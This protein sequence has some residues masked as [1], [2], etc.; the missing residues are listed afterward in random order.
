MEHNGVR[1]LSLSDSA[2]CIELGQGIDRETNAR[3]HALCRAINAASI[4]GVTET[5]PTYRSLAVHYDMLKTGQDELIS[6][7]LPIIDGIG[8]GEHAE[9]ELVRIPVLYGGEWGADIETVARL[10]SLSVDEVI[11]IH[12]APEYPV[13]MLGFLP[14][15][16]YLGGMDARIAAP[17]LKTPRVRIEPGS[18][19][20]A[21]EQ[22]GIYPIASPGGW[23]LIGRTPLS[24]YSPARE[25]PILLEAGLRIKF[26]SINRA[27]YERIRAE[28]EAE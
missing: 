9:G 27:E 19:G 15:F 13:Y 11:A 23:Q 22:T 28:E 16:C 14:G 20:I 24:L 3:V 6:A 4:A 25:K 21:G 5:V 2:L 18:V 7:L 26:Y 10:N 8:S 17:R 12:T 1:L